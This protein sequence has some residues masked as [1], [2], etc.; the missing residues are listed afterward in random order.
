MEAF[1]GTRDD[2][3]VSE[4]LLELLPRMTGFVDFITAVIM[5][6]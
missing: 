4:D 3:L 6:L 5:K 1:R 2:I